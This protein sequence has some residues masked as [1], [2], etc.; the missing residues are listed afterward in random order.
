MA[1]LRKILAFAVLICVV[2][3][4]ASGQTSG[5]E[6]SARSASA[7]H[8]RHRHRHH[9]HSH[10]AATALPVVPETSTVAARQE[11]APPPELSVI[12]SYYEGSLAVSAQSA[13]LGDILEG[14]RASTGAIIEAPALD[15]R[16][17]VQL[18]PQPTVQ[19]IIALLE[20]MHLN[21]VIFGGTSDQDRLQRIIVTPKPALVADASGAARETMAAEARVRAVARFTE[22]TGGDEGVW[23]NIPQSSPEERAPNSLA[24]AVAAGHRLD[25]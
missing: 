4:M 14:I 6:L 5:R 17:S 10:R 18:G 15:E 25:R 1:E 13:P 23:E 12:T 3:G 2:S 8:R 22:E 24:P 9:K 16:V 21:Y 20:G 7:R 19:A 11:E